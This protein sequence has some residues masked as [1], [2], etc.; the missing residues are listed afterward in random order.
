MSTLDDLDRLLINAKDDTMMFLEV[1]QSDM[2]P[3]LQKL[4]DDEW[5]ELRS[6]WKRRPPEWQLCLA[7]VL[8][9]GPTKATV[10]I[11]VEMLESMNIDLM[12]AA[13]D[14]LPSRLPAISLSEHAIARLLKKPERFSSNVFLEHPSLPRLL[15]AAGHPAR[16]E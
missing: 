13:L 6:L 14:S 5:A 9:A 3:I 11:L 1:Y 4:T 7:R 8:D 16:K 12:E 15:E 2:Y 10:P